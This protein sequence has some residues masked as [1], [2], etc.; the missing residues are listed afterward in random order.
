M[1]E[2]IDLTVLNNLN[3]SGNTTRCDT[4][5]WRLYCS[6]YLKRF[7]CNAR[8]IGSFLTRIRFCASWYEQQLSHLNLLSLQSVS[9]LLKHLRQCVIDVFWSTSTCRSKKFSSLLLMVSQFK[10]RVSLVRTPWKISCTHVGSVLAELLV[11]ETGST[12]TVTPF[13]EIFAL[14]WL[15][16]ARMISLM[17]LMR[18]LRNSWA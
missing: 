4:L 10:Q 11:L 9:V 7:S 14:P 6:M 8:I 18:K 15:R 17:W 16:S 13:D 5:I 1:T 12:P 3:S 2:T